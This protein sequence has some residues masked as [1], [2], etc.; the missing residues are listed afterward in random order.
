MLGQ[1]IR[2]GVER[3]RERKREEDKSTQTENGTEKET[4]S[5][6]IKMSCMIPDAALK[7]ARDFRVL[8][9]ESA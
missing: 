8:V 5:R 3:E 1:G 7:S 9:R 2:S 4:E 6:I